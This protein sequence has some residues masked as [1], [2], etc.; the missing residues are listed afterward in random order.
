M[1]GNFPSSAEVLI[2]GAGPAGSTLAYELARS[3]VDVVLVDKATF[4]RGKTCGGGITV[5]TQKLLPFDLSPVIEQ[6]ITGISFTCNFE[7][8]FIRRYPEPL[9]ITVRRENF[10]FFL[11]Q[12]AKQ[13]GARFFD[14]TSFFSVAPKDGLMEVETSAGTCLAKFAVGADGSQAR[15]AKKLGLAANFSY[16]LTMHSEAPTSIIPDWEQNLIHIDWGSMKR[17]YAYLFPKKYFLSMG[18]GGM[19]VPTAKMKKYHRAFLSTRWQK[20]ETLPFSTAGFM[21]PLRKK[22]GPIQQGRCLLLG[23]AAGL[24]DPFTGEGI[25]SAVRSAQLAAPVL[26]EALRNGLDSLQPFEESIDRDLMPELECSRLFREIFNLRPLYYHQKIAEKD[27]WWN[28]MAKIMRGEKTFLEL[29][30]K[31]RLVGSLLLRM[32]R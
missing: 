27:R 10:D 31:L 16:L 13:S 18:A 20:E 29:K 4:P 17:S 5:S 15:V 6:T 1:S 24:A 9:M 22:R 25:H 3:G 28:A 26:R 2:I 21:I 7:D 32:A 12:Q 8:P 11:V 14:H 19:N 30:K 23:D